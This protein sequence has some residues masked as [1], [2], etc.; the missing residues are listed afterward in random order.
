MA[1]LTTRITKL[2]ETMNEL[3]QAEI[4]RD[5]AI[6]HLAEVQARSEA[7][8]RERLARIDTDA[9][10]RGR[11]LDERIEKLVSA[12]G[13]LISQRNGGNEEAAR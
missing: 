5:N 6:S 12:I 3:A 10:A 2:E 11:L 1:N 4:R 13:K 9:E 7:E 8:T